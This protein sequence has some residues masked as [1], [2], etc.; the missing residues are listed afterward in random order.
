MGYLPEA[1]L[2]SL[3]RLG[4][5]YGDQEKFTKE[6]LIEK[7]SLDNV[8]RSAGIFNAD[9]LLDLN[10]QYIRETRATKLCELISPF[11]EELEIKNTDTDKTLSAIETLKPRSRT[12]K[13]MAESSVFFFKTPASYDEKG[14]RKFLKMNVLGNLEELFYRLSSLENFTRKGLEALFSTYLEEK[15]IKLGKIA[16]PLRVALTG[17]TA[18]PGLFEVM[19]VLGRDEVLKRIEAVLRHIRTKKEKSNQ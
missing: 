6:E 9:K 13:E 18:S 12:L 5:S 7:F 14:D 16:Q 8:G 10:A 3:A 19:E 15:D 1:L 4:W 17:R 2:N 11:L